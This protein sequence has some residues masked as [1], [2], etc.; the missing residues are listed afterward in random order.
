MPA[1]NF[2]FIVPKVED[3]L[4]DY[5]DDSFSTYAEDGSPREVRFEPSVN[6]ATDLMYSITLLA[7]S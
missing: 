6:V 2:V 3:F 7:L 4:A 1:R 5:L